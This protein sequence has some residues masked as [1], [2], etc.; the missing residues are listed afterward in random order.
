MKIFGANVSKNLVQEISDFYLNTEATIPR[1]Y[2][3]YLD[4]YTEL[5]SD[6]IF[7]EPVL[8]E[9]KFKASLGWPVYVY[10]NIYFNPTTFPPDFPVKG[11]LIFVFVFIFYIIIIWY[12]F[13]KLWFLFGIELWLKMYQN[14][15]QQI[16]VWY[17]TMYETK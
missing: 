1:D 17:T 10:K 13:G 9:A 7:V 14:K 3:F 12:H 6:I 2:K 8:I 15:T 11:S 4:K 16:N 5:H